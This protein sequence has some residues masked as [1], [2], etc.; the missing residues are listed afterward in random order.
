MQINL[1]KSNTLKKMFA[2]FL[3]MYNNYDAENNILRHFSTQ[4][5]TRTLLFIT[6]DK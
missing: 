5:S 1:A 2:K 4:Y 3:K 6:Q